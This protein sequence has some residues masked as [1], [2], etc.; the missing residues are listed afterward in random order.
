[1][2]VLPVSVQGARGGHVSPLLPIDIAC[3]DPIPHRMITQAGEDCTQCMYVQHPSSGPAQGPRTRSRP[4]LVWREGPR[5]GGHTHP[6]GVRGERRQADTPTPL[7]WGRG[8][9]SN[10]TQPQHSP[11]F[12][13]RTAGLLACLA[14]V[15]PG[16]RGTPWGPTMLLAPG[17]LLACIPRCPHTENRG[18]HPVCC[19]GSAHPPGPLFVSRRNHGIRC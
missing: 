11:D 18:G 10:A 19:E 3:G 8:T 4:A 1:M 12:R 2:I 15:G 9:R 17:G 13:R 6:A 16:Q 14:P 5:L 7:Q